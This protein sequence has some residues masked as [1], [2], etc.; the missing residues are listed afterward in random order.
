[1]FYLTLL[2]TYYIT[3]YSSLNWN[4]VSTLLQRHS[5]P[6]GWHAHKSCCAGTC[7]VVVPVMFTAHSY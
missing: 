5:M 7:Q 4:D 2:L 1:M 6:L 3:A